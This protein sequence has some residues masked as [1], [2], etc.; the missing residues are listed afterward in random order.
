VVADDPD[1]A[2]CIHQADDPQQLPDILKKSI[3]C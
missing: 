1:T 2:R 3:H